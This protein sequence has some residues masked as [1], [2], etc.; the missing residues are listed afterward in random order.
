LADF[1]AVL[2]AESGVDLQHVPDRD[3]R[4]DIFAGTLTGR[5]IGFYTDY[6]FILAYPDYIQGDAHILHPEGMKRLLIKDKKHTFF[7]R[8]TFAKHQALLPLGF[9]ISYFRF[10]AD[11]TQ[12]DSPA[13]THPATG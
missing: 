3:R 7:L 6:L 12:A 8:E 13:F 4:Q 1:N 10:K 5:N 2:L 9:R 11:I